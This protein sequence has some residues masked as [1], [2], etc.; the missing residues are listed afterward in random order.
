MNKSAI[1][2]IRAVGTFAYGIGIAQILL[3]LLIAVTLLLGSISNDLNDSLITLL[4]LGVSLMMASTLIGCGY[5]LSRSRDYSRSKINDIRFTWTALLV[6][7]VIF[8]GAGLILAPPLSGIAIAIILLLLTI[9][10]P[11]IKL[12]RYL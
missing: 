7:M 8:G 2:R 11:I 12:S 3:T 1:T 10:S 5:E 6:A 9:R 4:T